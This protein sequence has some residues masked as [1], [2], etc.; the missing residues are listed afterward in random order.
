MRVR[1]R[2]AQLRVAGHADRRPK[3][4][5]DDTGV[6]GTHRRRLDEL[7]PRLCLALRHDRLDVRKS[8]FELP[9]PGVD[10]ALPERRDDDEVDEQERERHDACQR[11]TELR[12][13]AR[14]RIHR[15]RN[16]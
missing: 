3:L 2:P 5:D 4:V 14:E 11:Q 13:D 15:S 10:E 1:E 7:A 16:R 9:Q 6:V 8:S 12:A